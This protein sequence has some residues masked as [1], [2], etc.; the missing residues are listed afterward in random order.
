VDPVPFRPHVT[1]L[2]T[3]KLPP[4]AQKRFRHG[5]EKKLY[6]RHKVCSLCV[7]AAGSVSV[8]IC[9]PLDALEQTPG[10]DPYPNTAGPAERLSEDRGA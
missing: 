4:G 6:M 3:S 7:S 2:K 8:R 5:I 10:N 9:P 1:L